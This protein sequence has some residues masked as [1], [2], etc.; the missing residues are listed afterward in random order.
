MKN[1]SCP[2]V[3]SPPDVVRLEWVH[4]EACDAATISPPDPEYF[5]S[6]RDEAVLRLQPCIR[7]VE[8]S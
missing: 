8:L 3:A 2:T 7:I 4:I 1:S 6:I 5:A